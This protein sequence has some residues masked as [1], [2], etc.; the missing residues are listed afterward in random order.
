MTVDNN[1]SGNT[2]EL[3]DP[4]KFP[5]W[6]LKKYTPSFQSLWNQY[7]PEIRYDLGFQLIVRQSQIEHPESGRGVYVVFSS[8]TQKLHPGDLLGLVPG[9]IYKDYN[10]FKSVALNKKRDYER[11]PQH[12][13]FPTGKILELG[14]VSRHKQYP[15][16]L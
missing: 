12:I 16:G 1:A 10:D 9:K 14:E 2:T 3:V 5:I 11:I 15:F 13:H 6:D 7:L 8:K 4:D